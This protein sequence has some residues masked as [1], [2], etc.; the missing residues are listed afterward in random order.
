[1][2]WNVAEEKVADNSD[3]CLWN[4]FGKGLRLTLD[5]VTLAE[6]RGII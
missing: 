2:E 6:M 1:M 3:F 4:F 5:R